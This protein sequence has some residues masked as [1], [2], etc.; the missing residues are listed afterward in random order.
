MTIRARNRAIIGGLIVG[1]AALAATL[2]P[3][4]ASPERG[5]GIRDITL[6]VRNMTFYVDGQTDPNPTIALRPGELVRITL[7]N[8]DAGMR[9]D[10][11]VQ[12]WA[13]ATKVLQE[14]GAMD[15]IVFRVPA[16]KGTTAYQCTPHATMMR[17]VLEIN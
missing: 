7:R 4:L 14:R 6:V 1:A 2:L 12:S 13:L 15:A 10:F 5:D 11:A 8:E 17:G 3:M 16:E 9:H